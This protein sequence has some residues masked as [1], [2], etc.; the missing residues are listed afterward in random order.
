MVL[1]FNKVMLI[2]YVDN[3]PEEST[4]SDGQDMVYFGLVTYRTWVNKAGY[5]KRRS[6]T[7]KIIV[8]ND[9]FMVLVKNYVEKNSRLFIEGSL[10]TQKLTDSGGTKRFVSAIVLGDY[11]SKVMILDKRDKIIPEERR[12]PQEVFSPLVHEQEKLRI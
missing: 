9:R 3:K 4:T 5:K 11:R 8:T 12:D 7:H 6:E 2:G 1:S 10:Q